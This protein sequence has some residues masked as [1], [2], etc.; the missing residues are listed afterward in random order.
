MPLVRIDA[1]AANSGRLTALGEAVHRA[2]IDAFAIPADDL[3]QVLRGRS[4]DRVVYDAHYFDIDRDDDI[5]FIQVFL[6]RG[7]SE[8]Q[9]R[10]FYR[11][12]AGHA[13]TAG[14]DPRNLLVVLTENTLA[15]WSFGD[16]VAQYLEYPPAELPGT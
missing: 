16:G 5:A 14:L 7:R 11:A 10:H 15:D 6:R 8:A 4:D 1:P 12:L 9:K 3:F 2:L 13:A